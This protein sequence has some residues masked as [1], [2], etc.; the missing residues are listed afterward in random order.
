MNLVNPFAKDIV[1]VFRMTPD[2]QDYSNPEIVSTFN[3]HKASAI[4]S[5]AITESY[6]VIFFPAMTYDLS[7][8]CIMKNNFHVLDCMEYLEDEPTD[9]FIVNLKTG[10]VQEIQ[11]KYDLKA[12]RIK[13]FTLGHH[14]WFVNSN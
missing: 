13:A 3:P 14:F 2:N 8:G 6:A 5:F 4:H 7:I 1:E 12:N 9:V 11:V 10:E